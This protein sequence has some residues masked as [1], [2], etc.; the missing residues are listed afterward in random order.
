MIAALENLETECAADNGAAM[1][2]YRAMVRQLASGSDPECDIRDVL[3]AAGRSREQCS[4]DVER[5]QQRRAAAGQLEDPSSV[6]RHGAGRRL[7]A[8]ADPEIDSAI[9]RLRRERRLLDGDAAN[10]ANQLAAVPGLE[11]NLKSSAEA[12]EIFTMKNDHTAS[13]LQKERCSH[14]RATL[15]KAK[16]DAARGDDIGRRIRE[17]DAE[18]EQMERSKLDPEKMLWE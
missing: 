18:I 11:A 3:A 2:D 15:S 16:S 8:T 4:D 5:L 1:A 7:R 13:H 12:A 10:C 17:V 14:L 9:E 6:V